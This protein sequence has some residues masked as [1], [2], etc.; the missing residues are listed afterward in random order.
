MRPIS[1]SPETQIG[2]QAPVLDPVYAPAYL[3]IADYQNNIAL[4]SGGGREVMTSRA[5]VA[6]RARSSLLSVS[7]AD[8]WPLPGTWLLFPLAPATGRTCHRLYCVPFL[9]SWCRCSLA[10][11]FSSTALYTFALFDVFCQFSEHW[12]ATL[13]SSLV[14]WQKVSAANVA[15]APVG[16]PRRSFRESVTDLSKC[17]FF[18][19]AMLC[20]R[21][22]SHGPVSVCPSVTSRCSTKTAKRRITQTTPHD[23]PGTLV[24]W[25][26]RSPRN[27][28]G[29]HPLRG[30]RMQV[31]CVKIGYFWQITGYIS[32]TVK[33]RHIVSIKVE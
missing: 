20:I 15:T 18:Y 6:E 9:W 2:L 1:L 12:D 3:C 22:T 21:G 28:T 8:F 5:R 32:K 26:Q 16:T 23:S 25:S 33:D 31:G 4:H 19:R 27:S 24:F 13:P 7:D 29:D 11:W 10:V 30:R 17:P 14:N